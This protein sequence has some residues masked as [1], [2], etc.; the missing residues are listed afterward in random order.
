VRTPPHASARNG[1]DGDDVTERIRATLADAIAEG[2]LRPGVK[3]SEELIGKHFGVS[4]TVV[5]GAIA[6][7]QREHLVERQRNRGAF[8]AEPGLIEARALLEA[9]RSVELQILP[10][11]VQRADEAGL[12]NLER[13]TVEEEL[14]HGGSDD[15]AKTRL[16]GRFHIEL[17]RLGGNPVLSEVLE[18]LLARIALVTAIFRRT[19]Q[20]ACGAHVHRG[21]IA[22]IRRRD[23]AAAG[24]LM[25]HHLQDIEAQLRLD[26]AQG[27]SHSLDAVLERFAAR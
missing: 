14:I 8:V 18:K 24:A 26:E 10:Y 3:L 19:R 12:A 4:R 6:I 5:R 17:A 20:D 7:L 16:A 23:I 9:R 21:L 27:D 1:H 2:A 15:A 22:A 11:V 25:E 13:M